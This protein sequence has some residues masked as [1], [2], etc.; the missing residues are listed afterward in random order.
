MFILFRGQK[1]ENRNHRIDEQERESVKKLSGKRRITLISGIVTNRDLGTRSKF[2]RIAFLFSR[3]KF[4]RFE[5]DAVQRIDV[6][7]NF[8]PIW[9]GLDIDYVGL[10]LPSEIKISVELSVLPVDADGFLSQRP[11]AVDLYGT[12]QA[13]NSVD[14]RAG[15][16]WQIAV[17]GQS[18]TL[19][20]G[21]RFGVIDLK[22]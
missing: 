12:I 1:L 13:T 8:I 3:Q 4:R 21:I 9:P 17:G 20:S 10:N 22:N 19:A 2:E 11:T 7:D 18:K 15:S 16:P 5:I 14:R 6:K